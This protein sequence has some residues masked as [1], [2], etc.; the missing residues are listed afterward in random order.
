MKRDFE[1]EREEALEHKDSGTDGSG[2]CLLGQFYAGC[3]GAELQRQVRAPWG[4]SGSDLCVCPGQDMGRNTEGMPGVG[5][6]G[7]ILVGSIQLG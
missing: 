3:L 6:L 1:V 5:F 7:R 2:L 4:R